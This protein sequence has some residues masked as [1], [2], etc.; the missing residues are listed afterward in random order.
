MCI[1]IDTSRQHLNVC[2]FLTF[3]TDFFYG[4]TVTNSTMKNV[5]SAILRLFSAISTEPW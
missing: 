5:I 1:K 3:Y 4:Q 2:I